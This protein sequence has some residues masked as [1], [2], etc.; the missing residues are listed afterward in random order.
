MSCRPGSTCHLACDCREKL[1]ADAVDA[2][3]PFV[4]QVD[5]FVAGPWDGDDWPSAIS[6]L[7]AMAEVGRAVLARAGASLKGDANGN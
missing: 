7:T 3:D 5:E 1:L 4:R 6:A 2:L